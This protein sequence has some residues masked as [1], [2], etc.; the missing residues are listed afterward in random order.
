MWIAE[1]LVPDGGVASFAGVTA[2]V[3]RTTGNCGQKKSGQSH[4]KERHYLI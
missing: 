3:I 2:N 1:K 4:S